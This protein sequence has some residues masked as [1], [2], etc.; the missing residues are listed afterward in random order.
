MEE[1]GCNLKLADLLKSKREIRKVTI[2]EK[3]ALREGEKIGHEVWDIYYEKVRDYNVSFSETLS[4]FEFNSFRDILAQ[5]KLNNLTTNILDL[6]G[7]DGSFLR[8]LQSTG[9]RH[10]ILDSGLCITLVDERK[11]KLKAKDEENNIE[12][13]C[14]DITSKKTWRTIDRWQE[15]NG[16]KNFDL[17]VCR[18]V[19]GLE[20]NIIPESTY[21]Y[22]FSRVWERLS[23]KNGLFVSQLHSM[24]N[25][26]TIL[27]LLSKVAGAKFHFQRSRSGFTE[28]DGIKNRLPALG[29]VK[30]L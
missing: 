30:T 11:E 24:A 8:D 29:I 4:F 10:K 9:R 20:T 27:K 25:E 21:P 28:F 16:V 2:D 6:M 18:G 23:D 3:K 15:N 17:V 12:V 7:G 5:R 19:G 14:G 26:E 1:A 13:E 22:I